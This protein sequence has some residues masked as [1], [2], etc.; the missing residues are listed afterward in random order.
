MISRFKTLHKGVMRLILIGFAVYAIFALVG[1]AESIESGAP[2]LVGFLF[3]C[4]LYWVVVRAIIWVYD[5]F[6]E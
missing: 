6:T 4:A 5:G 2:T 3:F 1:V